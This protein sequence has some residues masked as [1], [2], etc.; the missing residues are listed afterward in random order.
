MA[1]PVDY[2][3]PLTINEQMEQYRRRHY[4]RNP[5]TGMLEKP[6]NDAGQQSSQAEQKRRDDI[7]GRP[8]CGR[9]VGSG[10]D[11]S[12]ANRAWAMEQLSKQ[13][14]ILLEPD[15]A[16]MNWVNGIEPQPQP[17][18]AS[19]LD[20]ALAAVSEA[21]KALDDTVTKLECRLGR[22]LRP[23]Q[24]GKGPK[25]CPVMAPLPMEIMACAACTQD[26]VDRLVSILDRL[27]L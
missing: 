16:G 14:S 26:S 2:N 7:P 17:A 5:E 22:I 19:E 13:K 4:L 1:I 24:T 11:Q 23:E 27:V 6:N 18:P 25:A 9:C 3:S 10:I 12:E 8:V 21:N 15:H 20:S